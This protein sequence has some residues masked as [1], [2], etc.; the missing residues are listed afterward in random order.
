MWPESGRSRGL[1]GCHEPGAGGQ[2]RALLEAVGLGEVTGLA[3]DVELH[4]VDVLGH[5]VA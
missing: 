1:A 2:S 3:G 4:D 5:E